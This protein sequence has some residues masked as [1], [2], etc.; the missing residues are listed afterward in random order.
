MRQAWDPWKAIVQVLAK[1][2]DHC[3]IRETAKFIL[4]ITNGFQKSF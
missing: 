2:A 3:G 4:F 1:M